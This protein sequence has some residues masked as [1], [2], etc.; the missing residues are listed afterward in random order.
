MTKNN[1]FLLD[2]NVLIAL[3]T[4][5]HSLNSPAMAWF[6]RGHRFATCA[7]RGKTRC[8]PGDDG[9]CSFHSAFEC[10]ADL[11]WAGQ[12]PA[13]DGLTARAFAAHQETVRDL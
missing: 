12:R 7:S 11:E 4:R 2:A 10:S 8:I 9:R 1:T 13:I 6:D 3:S 5:D